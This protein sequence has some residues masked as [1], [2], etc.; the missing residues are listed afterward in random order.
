MLKIEV[1]NGSLNSF[2]E[3]KTRFDQ[4]KSFIY[5]DLTVRSIL[6]D[7]KN[8][9]VDTFSKISDYL[10]KYLNKQFAVVVNKDKN[11]Q[12]NYLDRPLKTD[13]GLD[14]DWLYDLEVS[15]LKELASSKNR[16]SY[17]SLYRNGSCEDTVE[18]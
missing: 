11:E 10:E 17:K 18:T 16:T 3:I 13:E 9:S 4:I 6:D 1:N 2:T 12:Y 14:Y 15:Q 8:L 5:S 7:Y